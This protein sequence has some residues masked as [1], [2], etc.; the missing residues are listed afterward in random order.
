[1]IN[2]VDFFYHSTGEGE[3]LLQKMLTII[4]EKHI[5][6]LRKQNL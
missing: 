5:Y 1:M 6:S 3:D 2:E 4:K